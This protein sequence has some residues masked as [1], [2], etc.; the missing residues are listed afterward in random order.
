VSDLAGLTADKNRITIPAGRFA[1]LL[2]SVRA[3][4]EAESQGRYRARMKFGLIH[5]FAVRDWTNYYVS[6]T[7]PA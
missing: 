6:S 7:G 1:A 4:V 5:L 3:R 2:R